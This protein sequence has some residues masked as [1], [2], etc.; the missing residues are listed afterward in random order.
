[1]SEQNKPTIRRFW[2]E[3]FNGRKLDVRDNMVTDDYAYYEPA[4]QEMRGTEGLKQS[5]G[6]HFN[7]FSD[8]KAEIEDVLGEGDKVV[9]RV[10]GSGTHKET[11]WEYLQL[12]NK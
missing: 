12:A 1:M 3:F 5:L 10:M 4:G 9:S 6:M 11:L 7:P 2:E 8:V